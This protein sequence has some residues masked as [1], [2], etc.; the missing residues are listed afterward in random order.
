MITTLEASLIM[1]DMQGYLIEKL[2]REGLTF[3]TLIIM[4]KENHVRMDGIQAEYESVMDIEYSDNKYGSYVTLVTMRNRDEYDDEAIP[5]LAKDVAKRYSPDSIGYFAQCLYKPMSRE[6][7]DNL[8]TDIMNKD[9]DAIRI[10]HVCFFVKGDNDKG[11]LK[12]TP[13]KLS[14]IKNKEEFILDNSPRYTVSSYG[15]SWEIP[16]YS[17]ETRIENPYV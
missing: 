4:N 7:Y 11:Y 5:R 3:P 6:E 15:K 12:V 8:T 1:M 2:E 9:I 17:M 16:S 14:E 13:Y 10:F